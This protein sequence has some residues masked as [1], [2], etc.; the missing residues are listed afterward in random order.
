MSSLLTTIST[1][2]ALEAY[3]LTLLDSP[4]AASSS[5]SAEEEAAP[6][7]L[8]VLLFLIDALVFLRSSGELGARLREQRMENEVGLGID[9][10]DEADVEDAAGAV[11]P[12]GSSA[13]ASPQED[14]AESWEEWVGYVAEMYLHPQAQSESSSPLH[15]PSSVIPTL[16]AVCSSE[17]YTPASRDLLCSACSS[18]LVHLSPPSSP[19][20]SLSSFLSLPPFTFPPLFSSSV[21]STIATTL[22][23]YRLSRTHPP[24]MT[25]RSI[26]ATVLHH[27]CRCDEE[28]ARPGIERLFPRNV[29]VDGEETEGE[30]ET[31]TGLQDGT[32]SLLRGAQ[33]SVR[34]ASLSI[35]RRDDK[36]RWIF[37][38]EILISGL[39]RKSKKLNKMFGVPLEERAAEEVLVR[40][41]RESD[42]SDFDLNLQH[43][44]LRRGSSFT[45]TTPT[46]RRRRNSFPPGS[47][48]S[49]RKNPFGDD[50]SPGGGGGGAESVSMGR[51]SSSPL[52]S[53]FNPDRRGSLTDTDEPFVRREERR[54]KLDKVQRILGERIPVGLVLSDHPVDATTSDASVGMVRGNIEVEVEVEAE[55]M[56]KASS[57]AKKDAT[58]VQMLARTRKMENVFGALPPSSMYLASS[59]HRSASSPF[60]SALDRRAR[61]RYS[62]ASFET[63]R[64]SIS[65]IESYRN[66]IASLQYLA[67][68]DPAALSEI[69]RVYAQDGR[70]PSS[71]LTTS[72]SR[73]LPDPKWDDSPSSA[74]PLEIT[75]SD[76]EIEAGFRMRYR[77]G[78]VSAEGEV[79]SDE[80]SAFEPEVEVEVELGSASGGD[81]EVVGEGEGEAGKA[82]EGEKKK[83]EEGAKGKRSSKA[84]KRRTVRKAQKLAAFFGTTRGEVWSMLLDDLEAAIVDEEGVDD[85]ERREVL[86]GVTRLRRM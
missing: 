84:T 36:L 19:P 45:T 69:T 66:S 4:R 60:D 86:D 32:R 43:E 27:L 40:R 14:D 8:S 12:R 29:V 53:F 80:G 41:P 59:H 75:D 83:M 34:D 13:A 15:I 67:E 50:N 37:G 26:V 49:P 3:A 51:S 21:L 33:D 55:E 58:P 63:N 30:G 68:T 7:L 77:S 39:V 62:H 16:S 79:L 64:T 81:E 38:G 78:Q 82:K 61:A 25:F 70:I 18:A 17:D 76:K 74:G 71:P 44:T 24:T 47:P 54:R 85:D 56:A 35:V 6:H 11:A 23:S 28:L 52:D 31:E 65:T 57:V 73:T 46:G 72:T 48:T 42:D 10:G 5:S 22:A 2:S 9:G 1:P 20:P